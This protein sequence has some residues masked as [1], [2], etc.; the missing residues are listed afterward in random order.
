[1][2]WQVPT[3]IF[4]NKYAGTPPMCPA[5]MDIPRS[6]LPFHSNLERVI[7]SSS[8]AKSGEIDSGS[9]AEG[10]AAEVLQ[11]TPLEADDDEC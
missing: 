6:S 4:P 10:A 11:L 2:Q 9:G 5:P 3:R 1:M 8:V 7:V